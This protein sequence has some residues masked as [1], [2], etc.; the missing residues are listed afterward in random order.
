MVL[1]RCSSIIYLKNKKEERAKPKAV[2]T[3]KGK[4]PS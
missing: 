4:L 1:N 3:K 2:K